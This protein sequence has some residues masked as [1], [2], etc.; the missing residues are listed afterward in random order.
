MAAALWTCEAL[1]EKTKKGTLQ[2]DELVMKHNDSIIW[3]PGNV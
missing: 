3:K 1:E 2:V